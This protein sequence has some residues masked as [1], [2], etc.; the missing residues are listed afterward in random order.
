LGKVGQD[1]EMI[2]LA[3]MGVIVLL[4]QLAIVFISRPMEEK[5]DKK[6]VEVDM[7]GKFLICHIQRLL[8]LEH[9]QVEQ[10]EQKR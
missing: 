6:V 3:I 1:P 9:L 4:E 8:L 7:V 5:E 2:V 10:E